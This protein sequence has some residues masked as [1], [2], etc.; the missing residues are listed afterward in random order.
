MNIEIDRQQGE[1]LVDLVER[2]L[3]NI[4]TEIRHTDSAR[5]R[6]DLRNERE[7]LRGLR[8]VLTPVAA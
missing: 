6:Q 2:R 4:S 1:A 5:L 7:L 3:G 8:T